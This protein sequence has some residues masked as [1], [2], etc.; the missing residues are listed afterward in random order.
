MRRVREHLESC[1]VCVG[2]YTFEAN[3]LDELRPKLRRIAV[4]P[5]LSD[6]V[7]RALAAAEA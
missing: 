4:P 3:L 6:R 1:E 2:E 7:F 5:D